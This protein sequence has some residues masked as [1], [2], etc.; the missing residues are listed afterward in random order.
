M[1]RLPLTIVK[2]SKSLNL[3]KTQKKQYQ[4]LIKKVFPT[5]CLAALLGT[6]LDL[7]LVGMGLYT[8]PTRPFPT[9]FPI[10][11]FFIL[12]GIPLLVLIFLFI[13]E[14]LRFYNKALFILL[15]GVL[16]AASEKIGES[17]KMFEHSSSWQH[18]YSVCGYSLFL[19]IIYIHFK[20]MNRH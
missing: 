15:I 3:Q 12:I 16:M 20:W 2:H 6:Y 17:L 4:S 13:C 11:I 5:L 9:I 7:I 10:N 19:T 18:I 14:R 1:E 8:F